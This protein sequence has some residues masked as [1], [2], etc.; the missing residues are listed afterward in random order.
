MNGAS[1][2]DSTLF[3]QRATGL[4]DSMI[5]R[6]PEFWMNYVLMAEYYQGKNDSAKALQYLLDGE[7]NIAVF[8]EKS[9]DIANYSQDLGLIKYEIA[10]I[11][12]A[13]DDQN[14]YVTAG[15]LLWEGFRLN[16]NS[17]MAYQ[18]LLQY[19]YD[20]RQSSEI[21]RATKLHAQYKINYYNS[22]NVRQIVDQ[23]GGLTLP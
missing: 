18:K 11:L 4:L 9:P 2:D 23:S 19:L 8:Y 1:P 12:G 21:A 6:Y 3:S 20:R 5:A 22:P 16:L 13:T 15:E 7:K 17:G 10:K 14:R